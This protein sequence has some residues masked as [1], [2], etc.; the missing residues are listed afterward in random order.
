MRPTGLPARFQD[1]AQIVWAYCVSTDQADQVI[2]ILKAWRS[3]QSLSV[4]DADPLIRAIVE[5]LGG[6]G[7]GHWS[8]GLERQRPG[9]DAGK[10]RVRSPFMGG[11][12]AIA[13][14]L[15]NWQR[16]WQRWESDFPNAW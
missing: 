10:G 3:A 8:S 16:C 9:D 15:E 13:A 2:P 11:G 4:G 6:N 5:Y 7:N 1:F 12:K 14:P